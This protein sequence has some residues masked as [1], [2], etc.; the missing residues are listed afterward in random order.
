MWISRLAISPILL[1]ALTSCGERPIKAYYM[2]S[3]SMLPTIQVNDR[4]ITNLQGYAISSPQRRDIVM[5]NPTEKLQQDGFSDPFMKRIIGL[6]GEQIALKNG[7]VY[8]NGKLLQ[9]VYLAKGTQTTAD[10]CGVAAPFL[11]TPQKIPPDAYLVLGDNRD[12]SYDSRCWGVVPRSSL[13]GKVTL[14][15]WPPNRFGSLNEKQ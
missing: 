11:S 4:V 7:G 1:S 14:I 15:F 5:F 6:P 10:I 8:I 9:E 13:I 3:E 2:P 12:N